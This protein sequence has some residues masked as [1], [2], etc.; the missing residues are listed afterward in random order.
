MSYI[1]DAS[2]KIEDLKISI[3]E[4]VV[5]HAFNNLDSPFWPYST[6]LSYNAREKKKLLTLSELTKTFEDKQ[7]RLL[8]KNRETANYA[9]SSKSK[10]AKR[11]E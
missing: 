9:P 4:A 2:A 8:N 11:S 6:I 1:K 3:F 5:I 7:I 10:K